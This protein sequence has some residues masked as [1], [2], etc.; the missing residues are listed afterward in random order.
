LFTCRLIGY[1]IAHSLFTNTFLSANIVTEIL[2]CFIAMYTNAVWIEVGILRAK[3]SIELL[4]L[5]LSGLLFPLTSQCTF[6]ANREVFTSEWN[7]RL[8]FI[9]TYNISSFLYVALFHYIL[10][11]GTCGQR[12]KSIWINC[13]YK[14]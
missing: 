12:F 13:K 2:Y 9:Y 14:C 3:W 4:L 8:C 5:G 10:D 6:I 7:Q 11:Y 1:I